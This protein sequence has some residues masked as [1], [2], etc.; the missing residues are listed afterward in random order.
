VGESGLIELYV[1][2]HISVYYCFTPQGKV[3]W[4]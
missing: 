4:V 2:V 3:L 1:E